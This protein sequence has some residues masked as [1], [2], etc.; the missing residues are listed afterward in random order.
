MKTMP[1]THFSLITISEVF[2]DF[3]LCAQLTSENMSSFLSLSLDLVPTATV[4]DSSFIKETVISNLDGKSIYY[5][6]RGHRR[7]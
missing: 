7:I 4:C 6:Y 3:H 2:L 1:S 5:Y